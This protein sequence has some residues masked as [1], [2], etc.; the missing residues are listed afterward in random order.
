LP[1]GASR[2]LFIRNY[3][4]ASIRRESEHD[5]DQLANKALHGW[6]ISIRHDAGTILQVV[7]LSHYERQKTAGYARRSKQA[8]YDSRALP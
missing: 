7:W 4:P 1:D 8:I 6:A 2:F 5:A 3:V